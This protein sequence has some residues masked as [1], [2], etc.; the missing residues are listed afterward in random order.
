MN[1]KDPMS[2]A[3]QLPN[4]MATVPMIGGMLNQMD[5]QAEALAEAAPA[6]PVPPKRKRTAPKV[7]PRQQFDSAFRSAVT[8]HRQRQ[9]ALGARAR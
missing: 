6:A 5:G 7:A 1:P 8:D 2:V 3:R 9:A 4:D